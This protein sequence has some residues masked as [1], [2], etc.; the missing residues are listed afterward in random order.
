MEL[1]HIK[2]NDI[3]VE[4]I[5]A[6][7][8][9]L[10]HHLESYALKPDFCPELSFA[11]ETI[12]HVGEPDFPLEQWREAAFFR[13]LFFYKEPVPFT[14]ATRSRRTFLERASQN[15]WQNDD[16]AA[17]IRDY[18]VIEEDGKFIWVFR[19]HS[20]TWYKHGIYS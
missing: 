14:G 15:W 1:I 3:D 5:L 19:D 17:V 6:L 16:L 7:Q 12:G 4:R 10:P 20:G 18:Y 13:P 8:N 11:H 9:K 2:G